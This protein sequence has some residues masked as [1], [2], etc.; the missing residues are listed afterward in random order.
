M[1]NGLYY[2]N[3]SSGLLE[4]KEFSEKLPKYQRYVKTYVGEGGV[5]IEL[6]EFA[7]DASLGLLRIADPVATSLV[8]KYSNAEMMGD[9]LFPS[10]RMAKESG[11]FPAFGQEAYV[12]PANIKREV[13]AR[14]QRLQSQSGYIQM[15]LSEY[16]LG[17]AIE[18]RERN[19]WAGSPDMLLTTKLTQVNDKIALYR[20]KLQATLATTY[21]NYASG[22]YGSG[23]SKAWASTGNPIKDM[24]SLILTVQGKVGKRPNIV[25]FTPTAWELFINNDAVLKTIKYGGEPIDPAFMTEAAVAKLLQVSQVFVPKAVYGTGSDG[26]KNK[27]ALTTGYLWESVNSACAGC[28]LVGT[29]GGMELSFGYTYERMNSPVVESYYE[30]Q[31]KSQ[32]WDY[33]HFFDPAITAS[34]A[35]GIYYALA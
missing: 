3:P 5:K 20:E 35:A 14:V 28:A 23:A 7:S 13:G 15:S 1:V 26:G 16:A 4:V 24:R 33:E 22:N 29:G 32:V 27:T 9:I 18:N 21:T 12:I 19:E 10:V 6:K 2:R 11:R 30:N 25:W 17:A 34:E 8:Q 31:T